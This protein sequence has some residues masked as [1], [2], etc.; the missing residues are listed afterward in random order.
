MASRRAS[1]A[2]DPLEDPLT[3]AT[4]A[5]S[6]ASEGQ[7]RLNKNE[8]ALAIANLLGIPPIQGKAGPWMSSEGTVLGEWVRA[9]AEALDVQ[10]TNKVDTMRVLVESV[11]ERWDSGSMSSEMTASAGGGNIARP[12]F[13]ALWRG[14]RQQPSTP[15]RRQSAA[16]TPFLGGVPD[17]EDDTA[18]LRAIRVRRG[19]PAFR[20]NLLSLTGEGAPSQTRMPPKYSKPP[21]SSRMARVARTR[22]PTAC[23]FDQTCTR[24]STLCRSALTRMTTRSSSPHAL[25]KRPMAPP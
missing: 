17:R 19:Q 11:G 6:L 12:A 8:Y 4:Y 7:N 10:Y 16:E 25:P 5:T 20:S 15:P 14:L 22:P 21:T 3:Q 23:C 2:T 24:C 18:S 13:D 9:V 1:K